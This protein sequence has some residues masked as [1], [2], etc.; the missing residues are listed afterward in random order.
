MNRAL[1]ALIAIHIG[2]C[3]T[4]A[5]PIGY[6]EGLGTPENPVPNDDASYVVSSQVGSSTAPIPAGV[7]ATVAK[8]R[9]FSAGPADTLLGL[10][11]SASSPELAQLYAE[12][13]ATLTTRLRGWMDTEID[14]VKISSVSVRQYATSISSI[15]ETALTRYS[16][17]S[18]LSFTPDQTQH[19]LR[20]LRFRLEGLDVV[21]PIGGLKADAIAQKPAVTVAEA[22]NVTFGEHT[23]G[24]A[25]ASHAWHAI[26][27]ASTQQYGVEVVT[28]LAHAVDCRTLAQTVSTKC[29]GTSCVGH[30]A[31]LTAVCEKGLQLLSS[32]LSADAAAQ[33]YDELRLTSGSAHLIDDNIDGLAD[34][35]DGTWNLQLA[36]SSSVK[37]TAEML[38]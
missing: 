12:L 16:I 23:F 35:I 32:Q 29:Y 30:P 20:A 2:G 26:N 36:T 14:K 24:L 22:G 3:A 28:T 6:G 33:G 11:Q 15:V 8:L 27:L 5:E 25:F 37:F 31:Q 38:R 1:A 19:S 9:A 13:P 21:V 10:A 17:D 34:R 18:T 4:E 7:T